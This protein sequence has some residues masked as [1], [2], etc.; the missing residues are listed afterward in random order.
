MDPHHFSFQLSLPD[1]I[2]IEITWSMDHGHPFCYRHNTTSH[3]PNIPSVSLPRLIDSSESVSLQWDRSSELNAV[4][5]RTKMV[6]RLLYGLSACMHFGLILT[7][8][9]GARAGVDGFAMTD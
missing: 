1:H 8:V 7:C 3:F 4:N 2:H 9:R 5:D 6:E